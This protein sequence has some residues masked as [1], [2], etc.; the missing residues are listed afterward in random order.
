MSCEKTVCEEAWASLRELPYDEYG[1][2]LFE[3]ICQKMDDDWFG[4]NYRF[5]FEKVEVNDKGEMM[6][7][8]SNDGGL[9]NSI[10]EFY[11]GCE[12]YMMDTLCYEEEAQYFLN[13]L[14][15]YL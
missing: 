3:K 15:E 5:K 10:W 6:V 14:G 9:N 1:I 4:M 13:L 11:D 2:K 7:K 12:I 8:F